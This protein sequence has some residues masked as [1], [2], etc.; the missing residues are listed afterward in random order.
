MYFLLN[1]EFIRL[2]RFRAS[3]NRGICGRRFMFKGVFF[4]LMYIFFIDLIF[5]RMDIKRSQMV[6]D[7]VKNFVFH[8]LNR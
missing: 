7:A 8:Q 6:I 3:V 2:L 1:Y 4:T 5:S